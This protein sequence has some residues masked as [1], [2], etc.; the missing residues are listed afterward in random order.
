MAARCSAIARSGSRCAS[1]TLPDSTFCYVH[2]PARAEDRIAASRKGGKA[3]SNAERARKAAPEGMTADELT[4]WLS[5]LFR[6]VM[7]EQTS[8][9]VASAAA[10]V[11]RALLEARAQGEIEQRLS[12][13]EQAANLS[14]ERRTA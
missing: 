1:P 11:A 14:G 6:R 3:R 7:T 8:P 5:V 9:K 10:T 2:D 12:A 13:L 4:G